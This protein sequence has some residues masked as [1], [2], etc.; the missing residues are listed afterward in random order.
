M[1]KL[2]L[3]ILSYRLITGYSLHICSGGSWPIQNAPAHHLDE[4]YL[5]AE[6]RQ[7]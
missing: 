4:P 6:Q 2:C 3:V 5:L 1:S 7:R